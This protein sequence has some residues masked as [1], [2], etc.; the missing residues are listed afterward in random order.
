VLG[1]TLAPQARATALLFPR[2]EKDTDPQLTEAPRALDEED[3]FTSKTEDRYPDIF[4]LAPDK[5]APATGLADRLALLPRRA[6]VL[7]HDSRASAEL[8]AKTAEVL[9]SE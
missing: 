6:L 5:A 2:V 4:G 8:L 3:F 1:M 7:T 9:L